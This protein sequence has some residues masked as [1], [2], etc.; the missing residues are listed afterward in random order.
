MIATVAIVA[1]FVMPRLLDLGA[2]ERFGIPRYI[3][4]VASASPATGSSASHALE[5]KLLLDAAF[6]KL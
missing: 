6:D 2:H 1:S 4:R 5:L 3:G